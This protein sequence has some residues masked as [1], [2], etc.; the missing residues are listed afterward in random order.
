MGSA[1]QP[2][3]R[4]QLRSS[5]SA[6]RWFIRLAARPNAKLGANVMVPRCLWMVS[7]HV[8][9]PFT[10]LSVGMKTTGTSV[11]SGATTK[12]MR[13][14]SWYSG[15]QLT[16]LS[17]SPFEASPST[18]IALALAIRLAWVTITPLGSD[19]DPDVN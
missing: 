12:P 10:K 19:V 7:I 2:T 3:T 6:R 17:R 18:M 8:L 4:K 15:S 16:P 13:P 5:F 1:P 9:G 14:M 11:R